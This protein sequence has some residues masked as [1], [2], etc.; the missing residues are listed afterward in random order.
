MIDRDGDAHEMFGAYREIVANRRIVFTW[1][2]KNRFEDVTLVTIELRAVKAGTELTL[3]HAKF[4]NQL[5]CDQHNSG[6]GGC[7]DTLVRVLEAA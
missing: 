3:T 4:P 7:L 5:L 2:G 1:S 6:W